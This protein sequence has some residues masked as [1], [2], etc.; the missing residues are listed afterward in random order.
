VRGLVNRLSG[1]GRGFWGGC[2]T[3]GG[4]GRGVIDVRL[5]GWRTGVEVRGMDFGTGEVVRMRELGLRA[6][7][8]RERERGWGYRFQVGSTVAC[9]FQRKPCQG[10]SKSPPISAQAICVTINISTLLYCTLLYCS[11]R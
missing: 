8:W 6:L 9:S 7:G 4:G 5:R 10:G 2:K 1:N 3:E 11:P